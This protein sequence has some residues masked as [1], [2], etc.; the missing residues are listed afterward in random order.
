ME[1]D[2]SF[3]EYYWQ[4]AGEAVELGYSIQTVRIFHNDILDYYHEGKSV[5]ECINE[6]F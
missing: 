5:E 3:N 4:V 2:E 6:V 1:E